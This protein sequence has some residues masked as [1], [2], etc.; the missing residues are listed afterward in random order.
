[1]EKHQQLWNNVLDKLSLN[2]GYETYNEIF[3]D[4]K[5]IYKID[6]G[7]IYIVVPSLYIKTKINNFYLKKI[8]ETSSTLTTEYVRYKFVTAN[9]VIPAEVQQPIKAEATFESNLNVNYTFESFVVGQSNMMSYRMA[10][11]VASQPGQV[12]NPLYIFGGVGLGKTHLMEAIGNY[13]LDEDLTRKILYVP[14][15]TFIEDYSKSTMKNNFVE[16]EKKYK[17]LDVLLVDDIQML[18]VGEKSQHEFFNLFNDLFQ[19]KKQIIITSDCPAQKLVGIMDRLTSR[20]SWGLTVDIKAPDLAHRVN[21]LK[22]KIQESSEKTVPNN[23]LE[24][25]AENF[26][27]NIRELEGGFNRVL[28]Y[29]VAFD[30][31]ITLVTAKEALEALLK[32]K[33]TQGNQNTYENLLSVIAAFYNITLA[34]IYSKKRSRQFVLPRQIGMYL[35]KEKYNLSY[36]K[37]G[38]LLSRDHTTV[39]SG[40]QKINEE[41]KTNKE[42][43]MA[44]SALQRKFTE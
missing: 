28:F 23:V 34:D 27:D 24:Y 13:M 11:K 38:K 10:M 19:K 12:A 4:C 3:A 40:Y 2:Y 25:I 33:N 15:N 29:C 7:V 43:K 31:E 42:M 21:I 14:A 20:F 32:N 41:L 1:M 39:I 30:C 36:K 17:N 26:T 9:E 18:K 6:N 35:L 22:R 16:F 5:T 44:V 37:I 8:I